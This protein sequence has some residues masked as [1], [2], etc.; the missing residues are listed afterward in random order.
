MAGRAARG[1]RKTIT[2]DNGISASFD[3]TEYKEGGG[4]YEGP[5]PAPGLYPA[6]LVDVEAHDT[7]D[8][9]IRWT[10]DIIEGKYTGWRDWVYSDLGNSKWKTQNILV[11][12]GVMEPGG[13]I[14]HTYEEIKKKA[15]PFR[16]RVTNETYQDEVK[17]RISAFL[18]GLGT[19][20]PTDD[21][22][23]DPD[24]DDEEKP[25]ATPSRR[26]RGKAADPEPEPEDDGDEERD[27]RKAELTALG[28]TALKK[29]AKEAGLALAD[30]RGK[31]AP[32]IVELILA[33]E[34]G[35]TDEDE[36]DSAEEEKGE[37][38]DLDA[39]EEELEEMSL[40]DLK[41]KAKEFGATRADMKDLDEEELIDLILEKAEEANPSF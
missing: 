39:L 38:L 40:A 18:A 15:Q 8:T 7:S 29:E 34:F 13:E 12:L 3:D 21:E 33:A 20:A 19:T 37:G 5:A 30:Y 25:A 26:S 14:N 16:A 17:G 27:E 6:K 23:E 31:K 24:F 28:I 11:A 41:K 22:P 2:Q 32:E 4:R 9:A 36:A 35:D 1:G 10:F